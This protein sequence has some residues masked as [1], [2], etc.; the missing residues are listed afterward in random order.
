[1][2]PANKSY[3]RAPRQGRIST[4]VV[5]AP[6]PSY[7]AE[8]SIGFLMSACLRQL[9]PLA[10]FCASSGG[11]NFGSWYFLRIL[12]EEDGL[13]Q[14]EVT[15]RV[16]LAQPTAVVALRNLEAT[17]MIRRQADPDDR[18]KARIYL[19]DYGRTCVARA[20]P[21]FARLNTLLLDGLSGKARTAFRHGLKQIMTNAAKIDQ[22]ALTG[23]GPRRGAAKAAA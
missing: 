2:G 13:T 14:R 16:G 23:T 5:P 8:D 10:Q 21:V 3:R 1:V 17:Q 4:V 18:R 15:E 20:L 6:G 7:S 12:Y 22:S 11:I 19:T 9:A